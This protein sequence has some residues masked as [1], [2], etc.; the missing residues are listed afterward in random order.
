MF[1]ENYRKAWEIFAFVYGELSLVTVFY[2]ELSVSGPAMLCDVGF[3]WY[4]DVD[5]H[6]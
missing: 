1:R 3:V 6:W 5:F 4:D 2:V